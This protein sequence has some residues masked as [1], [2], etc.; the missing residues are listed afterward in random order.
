[1]IRDSVEHRQSTIAWQT[2]KKVSR[3]NNTAKA[4]LKVINK[5]ERIK[6]WKQNSQNVL[7]NSPKVA[8]EQI[9]RI[10]S[11]QLDIKL[12]PFTQENSTQYVEKL[13]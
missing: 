12:G 5:Q 6:L 10:I 7:G 8:H 2:I 9:A 1:M 4:K 13:K 11:K 3:R